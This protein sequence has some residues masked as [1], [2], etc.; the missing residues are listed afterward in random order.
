MRSADWTRS[1]K[2]WIS[3]GKCW[4]QKSAKR[5]NRNWSEE[6]EGERE[7]RCVK[8]EGEMWARKEERNL[9]TAVGK[10]EEGM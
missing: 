1:L 2:D 6:G 10:K 8:T 7:E 4:R 3:E 5:E 9:C